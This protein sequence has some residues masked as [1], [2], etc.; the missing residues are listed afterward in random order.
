MQHSKSVMGKILL[1]SAYELQEDWSIVE[2]IYLTEELAGVPQHIQAY[3]ISYV[4]NELWKVNC[5]P[6]LVFQLRNIKL[7]LKVKKLV[8]SNFE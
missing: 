6:I 3:L 2:D 7:P 8:E 1:R 4:L 5:L